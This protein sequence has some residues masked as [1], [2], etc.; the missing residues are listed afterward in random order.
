MIVINIP[1]ADNLRRRD[2]F[3]FTAYFRVFCK[4]LKKNYA[5][6]CKGRKKSLRFFRKWYII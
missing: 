4:D 2:I 1:S 5:K 6:V 3:R